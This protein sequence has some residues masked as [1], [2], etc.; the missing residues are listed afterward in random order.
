MGQKWV[1]S[2]MWPEKRAA[3]VRRSLRWFPMCVRSI[4]SRCTTSRSRKCRMTWQTWASSKRVQHRQGLS[5][6]PAL[7]RRLV[8]VGCSKTRTRSWETPDWNSVR[9]LWRPMMIS[10]LTVVS[11]WRITLCICPKFSLQSEPRRFQKST[12]KRVVSRVSQNCTIGHQALWWVR[13][14]SL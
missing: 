7:I 5:V 8:I 12:R 9:A 1:G 2:D 10:Q 13:F 4:A 3:R 6:A 14:S 11:W